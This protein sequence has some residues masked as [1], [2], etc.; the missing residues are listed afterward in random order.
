[1]DVR[2]TENRLHC[3]IHQESQKL[4]QQ[5]SSSVT[6]K[7]ILEK[8]IKVHKKYLAKG[9]ATHHSGKQ[10]VESPL[11]ADQNLETTVSAN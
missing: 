5:D 4:P 7:Q 8:K 1:V 9:N 11:V 3:Q 2:L 10:I 6:H